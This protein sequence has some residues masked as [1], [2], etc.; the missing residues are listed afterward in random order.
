MRNAGNSGDIDLISPLSACARGG[1]GRADAGGGRPRSFLFLALAVPCALG[2]FA[3]DAV[4]ELLPFLR[5]SGTC[6]PAG[7]LGSPN[8]PVTALCGPCRPLRTRTRK[9]CSPRPLRPLQQERQ[10]RAAGPERR[11]KARRRPPF[12]PVPSPRSPAVSPGPP[13]HGHGPCRGR[14]SP[15]PNPGIAVSLM[16]VSLAIGGKNPVKS[17]GKPTKSVRVRAQSVR[18]RSENDSKT[19]R[20]VLPILT[21]GTPDAPGASANAVLARRRPRKS[22]NFAR[23]NPFFGL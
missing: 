4:P 11:A 6:L 15:V 23:A 20:F 14:Q 18:K 1:G 21:S 12:V 3:W 16:D 22:A 13:W 7:R 17:A 5:H 10:P 19:T 9:C 2:P 8:H